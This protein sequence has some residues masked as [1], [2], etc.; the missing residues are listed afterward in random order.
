MRNLAVL[1]LAAGASSRMR[2]PKQLLKIGDKTLLEI[3]L[4][5]SKKISVL[6][7]FCVLGANATLIQNEIPSKN[8]EFIINKK[9]HQGLSTSIVAGVNYLEKNYSFI[10]GVLIL[11]ADQP[12]IEIRYL[13]NLVQ[14]SI[15]NPKKIIASKYPKNYGVPAI[16]PKS[17]FTELQVLK[18]DFGAKEFLQKHKNQII[19]SDLNPILI[20]LDTEED[21]ENYKKNTPFI[22]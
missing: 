21:Y 1:V 6:P 2:S 18:G 5:K 14:L 17:I 19:C 22:E 4:E 10:N 15:E 8:T 11:L 7:I 20:D 13:E 3:V 9:Y 16:F 12:A